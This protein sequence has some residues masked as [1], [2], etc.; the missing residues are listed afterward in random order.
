[1]S[2][3]QLIT[4]NWLLVRSLL[5]FGKTG[6]DACHQACQLAASAYVTLCDSHPREAERLNDVLHALTQS[7]HSKKEKIHVQRT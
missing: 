4:L 3:E 7:T 6:P 5:A 2:E 1:M